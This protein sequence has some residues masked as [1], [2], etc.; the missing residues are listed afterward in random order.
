[1]DRR[2]FNSILL[3]GGALAGTTERRRTK[4]SHKGPQRRLPFNFELLRLPEEYRKIFR[5]EPPAFF[6]RGVQTP[7]RCNGCQNGS[8]RP[9]SRAD[10]HQRVGRQCQRVDDGLARHV[11]VPHTLQAGRAD[12][13]VG[14]V[15][16]SPAAM[17][18][19][20]ERRRRALGPK[21]KAR[22]SSRRSSQSAVPRRSA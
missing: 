18:R 17:P 19:G 22:N 15:L 8:G 2:H 7:P 13:D 5:A 14:R 9:R 3:A 1:M 20:S 16:Q 21:R 12:G 4:P 11:G 10:G 6:G